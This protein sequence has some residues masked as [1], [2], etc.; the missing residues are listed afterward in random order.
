MFIILISSFNAVIASDNS[1]TK[2]EYKLNN[3]NVNSKKGEYIE[4]VFSK[5]D[6]EKY[7]SEFEHCL[8][9][10]FNHLFSWGEIKTRLS[11]KDANSAAVRLEDYF[12][13]LTWQDRLNLTLGTDLAPKLNKYILSNNPR[14]ECTIEKET[15][16]G[17][18]AKIKY[19]NLVLTPLYLRVED[20]LEDFNSEVE[21]YGI[22]SD[23]TAGNDLTIEGTAVKTEPEKEEPNSLKGQKNYSLMID[24]QPRKWVAIDADLAR[25]VQDNR[26][27]NQANMIVLNLNTTVND[28]LGVKLSYQNVNELYA[29]IRTTE[30]EEDYAFRETDYNQGYELVASYK[31]PQQLKSRLR[32]EYSDFYR[33]NSYIENNSYLE[34]LGVAAEL[35]DD[36]VK[37]YKLGIISETARFYSR[38]FYTYE[39]T[40]NATAS[41]IMVDPN[42]EATLNEDLSTDYSPGYK[43]EAINVVHLYGKYKWIRSKDYNL[44]LDL[45]YVWKEE[46]NK[47]HNY[48]SDFGNQITER[49]MILGA[50]GNYKVNSNLEFKTDYS[51]EQRKID[52]AVA[53]KEA[54]FA[55]GYLQDVEL[56]LIYQ[57][58][59]RSKLNLGYNY[60]VYNLLDHSGSNEVYRYY[61][62]DF[63]KHQFRLHLTTKF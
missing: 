13:D 7:D 32:L 8:I 22:D 41:S 49:I 3:I 4:N 39:L 50:D 6:S 35:K 21:V 19:N 52:L 14:A 11:L 63:N 18:L 44:N 12:L 60:Q 43:D 36:Q 16:S 20:D 53:D 37:T 31:L 47:Y 15:L 45:R 61:N 40:T 62:Y 30:Y 26:D 59:E 42:Q 27:Q 48:N 57:L 17:L 55:E 46:D 9:S 10:Y 33:T 38:A 54:A 23:W 56:S 29:P 28:K 5:Y 24:Y 34:D 58:N 2:V 25:S 1:L 51:F